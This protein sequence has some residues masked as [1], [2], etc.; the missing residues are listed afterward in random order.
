MNK[1][2]IKVIFGILVF[3]WMATVFSFS[4]QVADTST[5]TSG[6]TIR[7]IINIFP[8]IRNLEEDDKEKIVSNLQPIARK[9]A[10]FSIYTL[11]GILIYIFINTYDIVNKRKMIYSFIIGGVYAITDELHQ[12]FV[13]ERSGEIRDVLI[14]SSGILIITF[15]INLRKKV[16]RKNSK[17]F[18]F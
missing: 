7:L 18:N 5:N 2:Y 17:K 8:N 1:K 15:L 11:G 16:I 12:L 14:D 13:P 3:I 10:H 6:N 4:N 9:L